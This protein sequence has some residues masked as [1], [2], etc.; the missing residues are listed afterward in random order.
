MVGKD[1]FVF[2]DVMVETSKSIYVCALR[3]ANNNSISFHEVSYCGALSQKL[4]IACDYEFVD[5]F[6]G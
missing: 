3:G 2:T 6:L 1:D 5:V 4:W